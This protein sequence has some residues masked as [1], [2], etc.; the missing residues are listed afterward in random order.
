M[1]NPQ[2]VVPDV[3][4]IIIIII[5]IIDCLRHLHFTA[6]LLDLRGILSLFFISFVQRR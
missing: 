2:R 4:I 5:V 3:F 1:G 6:R